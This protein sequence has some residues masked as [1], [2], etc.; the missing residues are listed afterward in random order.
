MSG[1]NVCFLGERAQKVDIRTIVQH[2]DQF[3]AYHELKM[4]FLL[5]FAEFHFGSVT[6]FQVLCHPGLCQVS[7]CLLVFVICKKFCECG[8]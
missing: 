4:K 5:Y 6:I 3:S 1:K 8:I 2:S 7:R